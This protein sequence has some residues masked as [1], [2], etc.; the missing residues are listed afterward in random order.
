MS[1]KSLLPLLL[2]FLI[3]TD[4][5]H[6]SFGSVTSEQSRTI[7][8]QHLASGEDTL[9]AINW[10]TLLISTNGVDWEQNALPRGF[11][12]GAAA[13]GGVTFVVIAE[14]DGPPDRL[15][16]LVAL[17]STNALDWK[18]HDLGI[19]GDRMQITYGAGQFAAI[20]GGIAFRSVDGET[21]FRGQIVSGSIRR[22]IYKGGIY[23]AVGGTRTH[24]FLA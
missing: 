22:M 3:S 23:I 8:N 1:T 18:V 10:R 20:A 12:Y 19:I 5:T 7:S 17:S 6:W 13:F 11:Q 9:V 15:R 4:G 21:W 16:P 24:L 14:R 2:R